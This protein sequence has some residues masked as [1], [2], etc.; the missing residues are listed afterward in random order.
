M[1][2][3][4]NAPFDGPTQEEVM[5]RARYG[6]GW[7]YVVPVVPV[8]LLLCA[9][10]TVFAQNTINQTTCGGVNGP[11]SCLTNGVLQ[12]LHVDCSVAGAAGMINTALAQITD[13]SGP[14]RITVSGTCNAGVTIAGFNRLTIEGT[15]GATITRGT[16]ILNSRGI[17]LKSLTFDFTGTFGLP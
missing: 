7:W 5:T 11:G 6:L 1:H 3:S 13:R 16:N 4:S 8:I 15:P 2:D 12:D 10:G 9:V 17:L 14:N